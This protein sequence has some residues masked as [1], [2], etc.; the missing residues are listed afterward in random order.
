MDADPICRAGQERPG[1]LRLFR[2][3]LCVDKETGE[4]F[5]F[6]VHSYNKGFADSQLGVDESNRNVLHAVVVSSKDNGET[7]SKPRDITADITK[8]TRTSGSPVSPPP[9][10]AS[11]SST[12]ST[13][14]V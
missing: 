4:I 1:T 3:I 12:A 11:S 7:W 2:P 6:F 9:V 5:L 10:P 8:V 13:R 14:V